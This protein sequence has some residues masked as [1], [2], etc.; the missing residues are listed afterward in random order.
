MID[1]IMISLRKRIKVFVDDN[2]NRLWRTTS[3]PASQRTYQNASLSQAF[4]DN[5]NERESN[6][7]DLLEEQKFLNK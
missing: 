7:K 1:K 2:T 5:E 4:E 6:I 3:N